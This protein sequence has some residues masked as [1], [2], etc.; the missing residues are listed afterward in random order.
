MSTMPA[1]RRP[2]CAGSAPVIKLKLPTKLESR[3]WPN[4][5]SPS[6]SRMPLMRYD[7]LACSLR[8]CRFPLAAESLVTP[9]SCRSTSVSGALVPCGSASM[10]SRPSVVGAVPAGAKML[11]RSASNRSVADCDGADGADGTDGCAVRAG[12]AGALAAGAGCTVVAGCARGA[13]RTGVGTGG[14]VTVTG[15]MVTVPGDAGG[16]P[17]CSVGCD[18]AGGAPGAAAGG[19]VATGA[20][21]AG[22]L[23]CGCSGCLSR[24]CDT[25]VPAQQLSNTSEE[26]LRSSKRL[27][28]LDIFET[29]S[30]SSE[31]DPPLA[32]PGARRRS[33][34]CADAGQAQA[35]GGARA[36]KGVG[37]EAGN[38]KRN[39]RCGRC[40]CP[41]M[42]G[43]GNA[44]AAGTN[45]PAR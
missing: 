6:G 2:Y 7:T 9:G 11:L 18:G 19:S 10:A 5:P 33:R 21:G 26:L 1:V 15:G 31:N 23:L 30:F 39:V 37:G 28:R 45:V 8:T 20:D 38:A 4:A 13:V 32:Q 29:R 36:A 3:N 25:A 41:N 34:D 27:L 42:S 22:V 43:S 17:G 12:V 24:G 35:S 44:A 16:A 14:G 40:N